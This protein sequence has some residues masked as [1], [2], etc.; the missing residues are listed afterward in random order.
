VRIILT[1]VVLA[2]MT[3]LTFIAVA[4]L[5]FYTYKTGGYTLLAIT[6]ALW[7]LFGLGFFLLKGIRNRRAAIVIVLAGSVLLGGAAISGPPNTSTDSARY[8]WDGIVQNAGISPYKYAPTSK[9][10][11][12][13]RTS[14]L[15]SKPTY[16]YYGGATCHGSRIMASHQPSTLIIV[17]TAINRGTVHTIYPPA[18]ELL[19]AAIRF[20]VGPSAT[21]W[22]M[23]LVG[24]LMSLGVTVLL[25]RFL[26]KR[27]LDVRWT[28]L[29]GWCPLVAAEAVTNSHVDTLGAILLLVATASVAAGRSWLGGI[30]L[31]AAIAT[32]LI[33]VIGAPALLRRH[34]WKVV[35]ASVAT[36]LLLYVPYV[37]TSGIKVLGYLPG[38]LTE[39][40][41]DS[42][43]GFALL[44]P[45][46]HG[47]A[48][49]VTA[50]LLMVILAVL[51]WRKT[52]PESPWLGQTVMIGMTLLI[53][54][55]NYPWY[56][57]LLVPMVA[58]TS[59][60][61]W[62]AVPLALTIRTLEPFIAVTRNTEYA[63]LVIV[64]VVSIVRAGPGWIARVRS[65]LRH[66]F[67]AP[68][69][70]KAF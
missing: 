62:L 67:R 9:H 34:P 1:A 11:E 8:A 23:Q 29:W 13:L 64:V 38:Y 43:S 24:L 33:P 48:A 47:T 5:P 56:G 53:V 30:A 2:A 25:L 57:L 51:V 12:H 32:K 40:G 52:N 22:P 70:T 59:R 69:F 17:C 41:Y 61:E 7:A 6:L 63:A 44:T 35:I 26:T 55:P 49:L 15:F 31:G 50:A 39:E 16:D 21:Y 45:I 42:G 28:A 14:W 20:V 66:P 36:F 65:E 37:I 3:A 60:W 10:L 54:S 68:E 4:T 58:M 46:L 19:F 27:Q 18:S